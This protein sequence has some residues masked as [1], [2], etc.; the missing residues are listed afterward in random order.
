MFLDESHY[1]AAAKL[2]HHFDGTTEL[3]F[4]PT[5]F[6][7]SRTAISDLESLNDVRLVPLY[8]L[9]NIESEQIKVAAPEWAKQIKT[10]TSISEKDRRDTGIA[11]RLYDSSYQKLNPDRNQSTIWRF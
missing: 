11:K 7:F 2:A 10:A 5:I 3:A 8:P 6:I 4:Q 9:C 1:H